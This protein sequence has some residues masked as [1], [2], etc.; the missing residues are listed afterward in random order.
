[1]S[2]FRYEAVDRTGKIVMGTMDA[3]N[4]AMVSVRLTQ[5]GYR[6]QRVMPTP[7]ANGAG[8]GAMTGSQRTANLPPPAYRGHASAKELAL[9]FRQFA[10]LVRSGITL[11]Q[12]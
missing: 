8:T 4:E 12:A 10:A 11:F 2:F 5:M 1:M 9:F 6:P 3:P 7:G